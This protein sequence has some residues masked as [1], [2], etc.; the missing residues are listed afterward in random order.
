[1]ADHDWNNMVIFHGLPW[2][3]DAGV[4]EEMVG[5]LPTLPVKED[6]IFIA[7]FPRSG[8]LAHCLTN[9]VSHGGGQ[10]YCVIS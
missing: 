10:L 8:L 1:M 4:T 5:V 3:G 2:P 7:S 9:I 6:D